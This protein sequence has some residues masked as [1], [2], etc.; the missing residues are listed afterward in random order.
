MHYDKIAAYY[1]LLAEGDDNSLFFRAFAEDFLR[2]IPR[3]A[4]ILD[5]ACGTGEQVIWLARQ[6]YRIYASDMS[7]GM[8]MQAKEKCM[9][10][11]LSAIFFRSSWADLPA[12][13]NEKFDLVILP[14]NSL[15]HISGFRTLNMSFRGVRQV[16][17]EKSYLLFDIRNWEKTFEEN[18][19]GPQTFEVSDGKRKILVTYTYDIR[20][21]NTLS[22]MGVE[23]AATDDQVNK[24]FEFSFFPLSFRQLEK[25]LLK[26][27]FSHVEKI[28]YPD[29][30]HYFVAAF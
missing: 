30:E 24:K 20:G 13:T 10:E 1:D 28:D 6:G 14:G 26:C 15:S 21:W 3:D 11:K 19:L 23:L 7:Q 8:L 5:C 29:S 22:M 25:S 12:K 17:K 9:Q 18:S 4:K 16:L 2:R 27:G